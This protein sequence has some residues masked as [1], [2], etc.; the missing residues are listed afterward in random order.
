MALRI[1]FSGEFSG[2]QTVA[3]FRKNILV[4]FPG[5]STRMLGLPVVLH[6]TLRST[7]L[8][9]RPLAQFGEQ[10]RRPKGGSC[11]AHHR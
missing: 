1:L 10:R 4:A 11:H 5:L 3:D 6:L 8:R 2:L 7:S 9:L